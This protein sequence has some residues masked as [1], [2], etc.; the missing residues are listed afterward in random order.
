MTLAEGARETSAVDMVTLTI[1]GHEISVPKGTLVIRAA[2]LMGIQIPRFCDHPLLDPVGACRQCLVEVEGQRKPLASCTTT[3]TPDMVV[4]TQLTS[5]A[6]DKAQRGVMELLL[7]NHPLDCPVCDKGGECPL[8]NQAMSNG[9]S[10]SR[11]TDA[12]RTYPKPINLSSQ[13]LLD[14]ER[15]VLCARCTRFSNQ[16]AGD[17]F[18]ELLERGALQQVGIADG[19]P[20]DSY[21]SG[22]TVQICPVGALT[23]T[24]YRF[25]ARPF[26]LV[27]TPSVC[28]HCASGCAQRTDHRRGKVLRRL[29]GDDPEV[30]EEWNC[31]KG[32]WA[33]AY[34]TQG[35]RITT[36][37]V[38]DADGSQRPASWSEAVAV[39]LRGLTA[40]PAGVLTGGRLTLED[41]Y[42]Y[43]KFARIML[44]SNDI[45]FRARAGS[46]EEA[47]FLAHAVAGRSFAVTYADLETAP[48]VVLAGLEP[49]EESPIIF[50]RLRKA[51]R[52]A[53][54]PVIAVA[55]FAGRGLAKLN[56]RLVSTAP[57]GEA[58]ALDGL[59]TELP[60]GSIILVGERLTAAPGAYS[61]VVRLAEATGARVGWV[62]RRAG[63]RGALEVGA[64]P[65]LLPG[66]R[67]IADPAARAE[68]A[69]AWN[70]EELPDRPGR[71]TAGILTAA[72]AGD[73]HAVLVGGVE[74]DDLPDP[75]AALA[76]VEAAG[77][78]VSLEV[79][80]SAITERADVVFPVAPVAEKSG[81]FV[82]WEGR[83]RPF[84]AALPPSATSDM[85]VLAALADEVGVDLGLTD[86]ARVRADIAR[87]GVWH[88]VPVPAPDVDAVDPPRPGP[89]EAVLASWRMLL[90]AGRLQDGEPYLAGTARPAVARL[91]AATA[92]ETGCSDTVRV[93]T[94][95]GAITLP[96]EITDM[97]D[98]VVWLPLNSP[99]SRVH[100]TLGAGIGSIVRIEPA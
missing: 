91:S 92:A 86:A 85:R 90:D 31:D 52:K 22:N 55:P 14:R 5:Q 58:N 95:R 66:G 67:P 51:V 20:F 11:F 16:I 13:V 75:A 3:V 93:S 69:A 54:L 45:D 68:V 29:A 28:E 7:I 94:D 12:K 87:L 64:A 71:D 98:R 61:A 76:A 21:F 30:N 38:R 1:D 99:G 42:G 47:Q 56:G 9:R 48:A 33:F 17:P 80:H 59:R 2:E 39:A 43:A 4:R 97:P 81:T 26:D 44:G 100:G 70:V 34:A 32:R 72:A 77:F 82:D 50:L 19:E 79:R 27:S 41:A 62:P 36:P 83:P 65:N 89:G 73:I 10:D 46:E 25:R 96:L 49:E 63:D 18:I 60:T 35:D 8:Q 88:G 57:G 23:G 6:A 37:L 78:V 40:G 24:A 84:D 53:G 74:V 15:C